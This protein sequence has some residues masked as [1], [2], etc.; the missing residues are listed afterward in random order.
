MAPKLKLGE[1]P[2]AAGGE[3][4]VAAVPVAGSASWFKTRA[5]AIWQACIITVVAYFLFMATGSHVYT[6]DTRAIYDLAWWITEG[7][8]PSLDGHPSYPN[9]QDKFGYWAK[10]T[11]QG[12]IAIVPAPGTA[13]I[14]APIM[15]LFYLGGY[16]DSMQYLAPAGKMASSVM[17]ALTLGALWF[18]M[19][20][21]AGGVTAY[22]IT[23]GMAAGSPYYSILS[24]GLWSQTGACLTHAFCCLVIFCLA[25]S[26]SRGLWRCRHALLAA[27]GFMGAFSSFCRPTYFVWFPLLAMYGIIVWGKGSYSLLLGIAAGLIAGFWLNVFS[28]GGMM[29]AHYEKSVGEVGFSI[30]W[31]LV[32]FNLIAGLFSPYRGLLFWSPWCL[33]IFAGLARVVVI[34]ARRR[35]SPWYLLHG[36]FVA[37][38]VAALLLFKDLNSWEAGPRHPSDLLFSGA[39]LAVPIVQWMVRR[40]WPL[41]FFALTLPPSLWIYHM[42]GYHIYMENNY[43]LVADTAKRAFLADPWDY[44]SST[45][46]YFAT[47]ARIERSMRNEV[48]DPVW[49]VPELTPQ[50][51]DRLKFFESGLQIT[52][53]EILRQV[54]RNANLVFRFPF[55]GPAEDLKLSLKMDCLFPVSFGHRER[56]E[57]RLNGDLLERRHFYSANGPVILQMIL[58]KRLLGRQPYDRLTLSLPD[59][60]DAM[61]G[62]TFEDYYSIKLEPSGP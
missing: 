41:A 33:V 24:Q 39:I 38:Q 12:R 37:A 55:V 53:E 48:R 44:Q 6:G 61:F 5:G 25:N 40:R 27:A 31:K 57:I 8:A 59:A 11:P 42:T 46:R 7:N 2:G 10:K 43:E 18:I 9:T 26:P 54:S 14:A 51:P 49:S 60:P 3:A 58:P 28:S 35:W 32:Y 23:I 13:L 56:I 19:F 47:D 52:N 20:R 22:L 30:V 16:P 50:S 29:G 17:I 36:G 45:Y 4:S 15:K 62:N 1:T 21:M 34:T